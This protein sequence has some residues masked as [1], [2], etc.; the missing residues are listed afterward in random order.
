MG[1]SQRPPVP[2]RRGCPA[3]CCRCLRHKVWM[4]GHNR[5]RRVR[6]SLRGSDR[7]STTLLRIRDPARDGVRFHHRRKPSAPN[8]LEV[9]VADDPVWFL[10]SRRSVDAKSRRLFSGASAPSK[11]VT[12]IERQPGERLVEDEQ[13]AP[14]VASKR[15]GTDTVLCAAA[16]E[17]HVDRRNSHPHRFGHASDADGHHRRRMLSFQEGGLGVPQDRVQRTE[18]Y[19]G[20]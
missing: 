6:S 13:G 7:R 18:R 2:G 4:A 8:P 19:T 3:S 9:F 12:V 14:R 16:P 1:R 5:R 11:M 20:G 10:R 17:L 15:V